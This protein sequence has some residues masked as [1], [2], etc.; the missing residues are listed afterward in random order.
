M[1][2]IPINHHFN[3]DSIIASIPV[4]S[5]LQSRFNY[6]LNPDQ[7]W[8]QSRSIMASIPDQ[9]SFQSQFNHYGSNRFHHDFNN[10][11]IITSIPIQSWLWFRINHGSNFGSIKSSIWI[12][13]LD[14]RTSTDSII[15]SNR[16]NQDFDPDQSSLQSDIIMTSIPINHHLNHYLIMVSIRI[17]H[18]LFTIQLSLRFRKIIT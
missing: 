3:H 2:S 17:N 7:S 18:H 9:S 8:L 13:N 6:G 4:Q 5:S 1:T 15:A 16:I 11:L 10:D 12:N 14:Q